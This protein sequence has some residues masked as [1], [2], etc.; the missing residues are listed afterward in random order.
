MP[1]HNGIKCSISVEGSPLNEYLPSTQDTTC[2]V[3]LA[4]REGQRYNIELEGSKTGSQWHKIKI[5]FDGRQLVRS[6]T[7]GSGE[8]DL[9]R[10][11]DRV[12]DKIQDNGSYSTTCFEF[13]KINVVDIDAHSIQPTN[14]Q[15]NDLGSI[16]ITI[17]RCHAPHTSREIDTSFEA[18]GIPPINEKK[19][20]GRPL[21]HCTQFNPQNRVYHENKAIYRFTNLIDPVDRPYATF[22]FNYMSQDL[23]EAQ[24]IA[25]RPARLVTHGNQAHHIDDPQ[26][27]QE[28]IYLRQQLKDSKRKIKDEDEDTGHPSTENQ[29]PRK[30]A[31]KKRFVF[32][33]LTKED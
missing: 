16:K 17:W 11:M 32:V 21:S 30:R 25:P 12:I 5:W 7:R 22:I 1:T 24:G 33:D 3:S 2:T 26:K 19:I 8:K 14:E 29:A 18:D 27:D 9:K 28:V 20:K 23:L 4:A 10:T 15:I 13:G 31:K 6:V